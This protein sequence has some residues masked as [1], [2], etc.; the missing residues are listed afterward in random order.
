MVH[1]HDCSLFVLRECS[2]CG[3]LGAFLYYEQGGL[4]SLFS[5]YFRSRLNMM[6]IRELACVFCVPDDFADVLENH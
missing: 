2:D 4:K 1:E 5:N 6:Q 3:I